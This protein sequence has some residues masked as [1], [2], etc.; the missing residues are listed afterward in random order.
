MIETPATRGLGRVERWLVG[1]LVFLTVAFGVLVEVR[2]ALLSRRMG[3]LDAYLRASWAAR[4]GK[5]IYEVKDENNW[6]FCYPPFYALLM[7]PLADPPQNAPE[8]GYVPFAV[9]AGL[10]YVL[11]I[12]L[13]GL[14]V[15]VLARALEDTA[16]DD[17]VRLQPRWCRRWWALRVWPVIFCLPP[18]CQVAMKGQVNLLVLA[19][20]CVGMAGLVRQQR[21]RAGVCAA[22]AA[23][24]K[25]IPVFLMVHAL[26]KRDVRALAGWGL[27]LFLGLVVF[28]VLVWGPQ[29]TLFEY[30]RF[31]T[32][33]FGPVLQISDDHSR[34][35]ELLGA[36]AT[37]AIGLKNLIHNWIYFDRD[38]RPNEFHPAA[39]WAYRIIG[40][41]MTLLVLWPTARAAGKTPWFTIHQF[42]ALIVVMF[43][44]SPVSHLH[45]V[46]FCL[47]LVQSLIARRFLHRDNLRLGWGLSLMLVVFTLTNIVPSLPNLDR[48]KDLCVPMLGAVPLW[49][50]SVVQLWRDYFTSREAVAVVESSRL[51]A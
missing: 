9:S 19:L 3:D 23:C 37:D 45:Y 17:R 18:A 28:P 13:L 29:W 39:V 12:G 11:N 21:V 33:M 24:I 51:A 8:P 48:L 14:A 1:L 22:F 38:H 7:I 26:W 41:L 40:G 25:V 6:H 16:D 49:V 46:V 15:H 4:V 43:F 47:P 10:F 44:T 5:D 30:Q 35:D 27:G 20:L 31:T 50:L 32:V 2:T 42:S 34:Q 36:N